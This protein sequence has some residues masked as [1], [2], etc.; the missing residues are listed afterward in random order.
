MGEGGRGRRRDAV[1]EKD[2]RG[3]EKVGWKERES[4]MGG[5]GREKEGWR[6]RETDTHYTGKGGER[7]G[8][9]DVGRQTERQ[10]LY[11]GRGR[12]KEEE[13]GGRERQCGREERYE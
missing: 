6:E 13:R 12:E 5:G 10:A 8:G 1:R 9:G 7:G 3:R 4:D 2:D 11:V